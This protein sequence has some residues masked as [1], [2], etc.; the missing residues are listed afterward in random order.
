MR[1][2]ISYAFAILIVALG[3]LFVA[4]VWSFF[5]SMNGQIA[6]AMATIVAT[7]TAAVWTFIKTKEK[8]IE[9]RQFP[10]RA[11]PY[12]STWRQ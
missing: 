2:Q 12:K 7:V 3:D 4:G 11:E 8:D 5:T 6:G 1:K 10:A 9:A